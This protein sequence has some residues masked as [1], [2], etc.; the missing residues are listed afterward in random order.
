MCFGG[1]VKL[2]LGIN[3]GP[4]VAGRLGAGGDAAYAVTGDTVNTAAR[5]LAASEEGQILVSGA[6]HRLTAHAFAF[7]PLPAMSLKGKAEPVELWRLR[8]L[9]DASPSG[10][11]GDGPALTGPLVGRRDELAQMLAAFERAA[12]GR[13][14]ILSLVGEAG[15]G[16][17]RLVGELFDTLEA[18]GRLAGASVRRSICSSFG[19]QAY[20]VLRAFLREGYQLAP[21]DSL[22]AAVD[23]LGAGLR[24]LGSDEIEAERIAPVLA[25]ML[26][27]ESSETL[28]HLE[29]EQL[30]RQIFLAT[31]LVVERRL[32]QGPMILVVENLHWADT[33]SI[34]LL[35]FVADRL[36]DRPLMLLVTYRPG[37]DEQA[38]LTTR[39]AHTSIRLTP[40]HDADSA[41]L[42]QSLLG[43]PEQGLP[44]ALHALVV[45]RAGGNPL[46][47][48]EI[49]RTLVAAGVL[50]RGP[51]GWVC[52]GDVAT[53]DVPP[54]IQGLLLSRMDRLPADARRL[55]Q[56]AAVLGLVFGRHVL[57][58]M[59]GA[60]DR[61][62]ATLDLL[63]D[64]ELIE[65]V[66]HAARTVEP[67]GRQYR[68][69]QALV[70]EVV[71]QNLLVSR[72]TESHDRAGRAYETL[73]GGQPQRA[74][75]I[76]AP[77]PSL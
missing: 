57:S 20:A 52:A 69:T 49:V 43:S 74:E 36:S 77:R 31:R 1:P 59:A 73:C 70:Q 25:H 14:Q 76:E 23:K 7:E 4:V 13:A 8:G 38:L 5:L 71:Y 56:E 17:S 63:H 32:Q 2:H 58:V 68:F 75:D 41:A 35:R 16:K 39:A 42:L 54:T 72:R 6:T 10:H 44:P 45:Q 66:P 30:Q 22:E 3:T 55:L 64:A 47:I 27:I 33:A 40:L 24:A 37:M 18:R 21:G 15:T 11:G 29:P 53:L 28:Q 34:E 67:A 9:R 46:Y 19:E 62:D 60:P 51:R 65:E 50:A 26:G 61:F 48:V 12:S